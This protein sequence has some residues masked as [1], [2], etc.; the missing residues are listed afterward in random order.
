MTQSTAVDLDHEAGKTQNIR[1][2]NFLHWSSDLLVPVSFVGSSSLLLPLE[3]W[4]LNCGLGAVVGD[5]LKIPQSGIHTCYGMAMRKMY[6]P[7]CGP[8]AC[9][10]VANNI[11][12]IAR[13]LSKAK[14]N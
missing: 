9:D 8:R 12:I 3:K 14:L 1:Q 11:S 2:A 13:V 5:I 7:V 10:I 6:D 4:A